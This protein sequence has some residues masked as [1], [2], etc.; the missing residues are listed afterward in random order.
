MQQ[1]IHFFRMAYSLRYRKS[2]NSKANDSIPAIFEPLDN[3]E[4]NAI[5]AKKYRP[6]YYRVNILKTRS[7]I[8][9][10]S[11]VTLL[12]LA[13]RLWQIGTT[14]SS[15]LVFAIMKSSVN[16]SSNVCLG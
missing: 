10:L 5:G 1:T 14:D 2:A 4:Y 8:A 13:T 11:F 6:R 16:K 3:Y 15:A 9:T 12:T 7:E